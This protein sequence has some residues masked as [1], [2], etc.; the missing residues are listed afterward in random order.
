[1]SITT[2]SLPLPAPL[3]IDN[4]AHTFFCGQQH[5]IPSPD[6]SSLQN[7]F[8]PWRSVQMHVCECRP[9]A[10]GAVPGSILFHAAAGLSD[11]AIVLLSR[12]EGLQSAGVAAAQLMSTPPSPRSGSSL[13]KSARVCLCLLAPL[14]CSFLCIIHALDTHTATFCYPESSVWCVSQGM[15]RYLCPSLPLAV[16]SFAAFVVTAARRTDWECRTAVTLVSWRSGR[17]IA[18]AGEA[19]NHNDENRV[20]LLAFSELFIDRMR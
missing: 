16:S 5:H 17:G 11:E 18:A 6:G 10:R 1:M 7:K 13:C 20:V 8:C 9:V 15:S 3:L 12:C 19:E 4:S 14:S 2:K